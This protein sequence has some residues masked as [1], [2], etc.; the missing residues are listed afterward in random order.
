MFIAL[1]WCVC[2]FFF[3]HRLCDVKR[4]FSI[5]FLLKERVF[6]ILCQVFCADTIAIIASFDSN[7]RC[8]CLVKIVFKTKLPFVVIYGP[9]RPAPLN[10]SCVFVISQLRYPVPPRTIESSLSSHVICQC[11]VTVVQKC[12]TI[13]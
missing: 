12:A 11:L 3:S 10:L 7:G 9:P 8:T 1:M 13:N 5:S 2:L 6:P 4:L